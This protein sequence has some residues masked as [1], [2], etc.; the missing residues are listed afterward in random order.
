MED[1]ILVKLAK[2]PGFWVMAAGGVLFMTNLLAFVE[3]EGRGTLKVNIVAAV[4]VLVAG[5]FILAG[6]LK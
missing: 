6:D 1:Y 2:M 4:V 5:F 3:G